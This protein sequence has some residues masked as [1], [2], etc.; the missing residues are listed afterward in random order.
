T[1]E[2]TGR[3]YNLVVVELTFHGGLQDVEK[4]ANLNVESSEDLRKLLESTEV[5]IE[6]YPRGGRAEIEG[7][8]LIANRGAAVVIYAVGSNPINSIVASKIANLMGKNPLVVT[9]GGADLQVETDGKTLVIKGSAPGGL[10]V[11]YGPAGPD[12]TLN[13]TSRVGTLQVARTLGA[14]VPPLISLFGWILGPLLGSITAT[15]APTFSGELRMSPRGVGVAT[16]AVIATLL[17]LGI[18]GRRRSE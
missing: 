2:T 17:L 9:L 7:L 15:Y 13:V 3:T 16:P 4:L 18:N 10:M 8:P 1:I 6:C 14:Q 12:Q 5:R 11:I